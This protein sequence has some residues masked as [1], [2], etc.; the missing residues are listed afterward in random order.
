[1]FIVTASLIIRKQQM[2]TLFDTLVQVKKD[3]FGTWHFDCPIGLW[4][5]SGNSKN[6]ASSE[7]QA[8]FWQCLEDGEYNDLAKRYGIVI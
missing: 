7:A 4:G 1:M 8:Y 3:K 2:K 5:V 6:Q